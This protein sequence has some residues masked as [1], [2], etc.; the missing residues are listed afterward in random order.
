MTSEVEVSGSSLT[1]K[2][3]S[4]LPS[5]LLIIHL[6]HPLPTSPPATLSLFSI[7]NSK[8]EGHLNK[9][10]MCFGVP[11]NEFSQAIDPTS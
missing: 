6:A 3:L 10:I 8:R 5:L 7:V 2:C 11:Q 4:Q 9:L 1:Y